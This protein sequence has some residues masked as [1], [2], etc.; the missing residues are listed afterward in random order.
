V[1]A[2]KSRK[3]VVST[4]RTPWAVVA[5]TVGFALLVW[6]TMLVGA[7]VSST[8]SGGVCGGLPDCLGS[9]MPS[10]KVDVSQHIHMQHRLL[11]VLV[12]V[13]SVVQM[14]VVKRLAPTLRPQAVGAHVMVWGQVLLGVL[15]LYSFANYADFYYVLSIV[16]L[17]WGTLLWVVAVRLALS[18]VRGRG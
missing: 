8:H 16:H 1:P 9:W 11:A 3:T 18:A 14:V 12:L 15:T 7:A 13:L 10:P 5:V 17:G 2:K 4:G 6:V